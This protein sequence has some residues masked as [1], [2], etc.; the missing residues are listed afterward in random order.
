MQKELS[1]C[2]HL[3]SIGV[4]MTSSG[5]SVPKEPKDR[6]DAMTSTKGRNLGGRVGSLEIRIDALVPTPVGLF[7][8]KRI[9]S[10]E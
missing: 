8:A 5:A 2:A 9:A 10:Q 4:F 3:A 6:A 7:E 1:A